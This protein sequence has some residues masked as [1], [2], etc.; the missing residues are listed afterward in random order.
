LD[1]KNFGKKPNQY[2]K[3]TT[4]KLNSNYP[5][6]TAL[7]L[8]SSQKVITL[9][10]SPYQ[11]DDPL[12]WAELDNNF[13]L[14]RY[15]I[16]SLV[17][18]IAITFAD[19]NYE[20]DITNL[21]SRIGKLENENLNTRVTELE[22]F[23]LNTR[24]VALEGYNMPVTLAEFGNRIT[25]V[26]TADS[27]FDTRL[28]EVESQIPVNLSAT[29]SGLSSDVSALQTDASSFST[30]LSTFETNLT[31]LQTDV[32]GLQ[33]TVDNLPTP[34]GSGLPVGYVLADDFCVGDGVT[35]DTANLQAAIDSLGEMGG[36]VLLGNKEYLLASNDG[37]MPWD[38]I[39]D[40]INTDQSLRGNASDGSLDGTEDHTHPAFKLYAWFRDSVTDDAAG[41]LYLVGTWNGTE[42]SG[43]AD[44]AGFNYWASSGRAALSLWQ[45][46]YQAEYEGSYKDTRH[47]IVRE[48]VTIRGCQESVG[49]GIWRGDNIG[50]AVGSKGS[51][52]KIENSTTLVMKRDT[53]LTNL[54]VVNNGLDGLV[55]SFS[56]YGVR[57]SADDVLIQNCFIGGFEYGIYA[58]WTNPDKYSKGNNFGTGG[59]LRVTSCNMDNINCIQVKGSYDITYIDKVHCWTFLTGNPMSNINQSIGWDWTWFNC[60]DG[61]AFDLSEVNDWTKITDSFS[62]GYRIGFHVRGCRSVIL[63]GCG[64]DNASYGMTETL[65]NNLLNHPSQQYKDHFTPIIEQH[66]A[67]REAGINNYNVM[68]GSIGFKITRNWGNPDPFYGDYNAQ[69]GKD[70][71]KNGY[72]DDGTPFVNAGEFVVGIQYTIWEVGTTNWLAIGATSSTKGHVFT[73]TGPGSGDGVAYS[74]N[75]KFYPGTGSIMLTNCQAA[76]QETAYTFDL[77]TNECARMSASSSWY[78][79]THILASATASISVVNQ[80]VDHS[81][82]IDPSTGLGSIGIETRDNANI[83]VTNVQFREINNNYLFSNKTLGN[84]ISITGQQ[85]V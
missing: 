15:S 54:T 68:P 75:E 3:M 56:G 24:M 45:G 69:F 40:Y 37:T 70:Y 32:T 22:D 78:C 17:D 74:R 13:E 59:R 18:D 81:G 33:T 82:Y 58:N 38:L 23:D 35:D 65:F 66:Y 85:D 8:T 62:Y 73:A 29:V 20:S 39:P 80:L 1:L 42:F 12:S 28:T 25:E 4:Q 5:E 47:V 55:S 11:S 77:H 46:L 71:N 6:F 51:T 84:N 36:T 34:S 44:S 49:A 30:S 61:I 31:G 43:G 50:A 7:D 9:R 76:A 19:L 26:E 52:I 72:I 64:A 41:F 57:P 67:D 63:S 2:I 14:L 83:M 21:S 48:H 53:A 79:G 27:G 16:N 60:R 10:S